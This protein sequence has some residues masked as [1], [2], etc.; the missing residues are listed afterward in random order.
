MIYDA[1]RETWVRMDPV[2]LAEK[3]GYRL[4][5]CVSGAIG[6]EKRRGPD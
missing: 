4:A 1:K 6:C 5:E 3:T 2:E